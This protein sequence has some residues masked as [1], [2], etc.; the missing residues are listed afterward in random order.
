VKAR[1][2]GHR[3]AAENHCGLR[4]AEAVPG[5]EQEKLLVIFD[6][7]PQG[8]EKSADGHLVIARSSNRGR[9]WHWRRQRRGPTKGAAM[10]AEKVA[11]D[12]VEPR[13][14]ILVGHLIEAPPG[15]LHRRCYQVI[16]VSLRG[17]SVGHVSLQSGVRLP[18]QQAKSRFGV[19]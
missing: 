12:P 13:Q 19:H 1:A 8:S 6:Q 11:G 15:D 7:P 10:V 18:K 14:R 2:S 5:D 16:G 9:D 4:G 17:S 3:R